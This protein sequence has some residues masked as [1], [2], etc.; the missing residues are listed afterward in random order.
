[1]AHAP[2]AGRGGRLRAVDL[3]LLVPAIGVGLLLL[4]V[5]VSARTGEP[6]TDLLR[7]TTV[8]N[9]VPIALGTDA[10]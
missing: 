5:S 1:M 2:S 9:L 10:P 3:L 6:V 8:K 4:A 7:P